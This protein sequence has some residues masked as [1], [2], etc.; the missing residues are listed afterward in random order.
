M[1][2]ACELFATEKFIQELPPDIGDYV[3]EKEPK[4]VSDAADLAAKQF[5]LQ[6]IDEFKYDSSK[7]WTG[8]AKDK[9]SEDKPFRDVRARF[10]GWHGAKCNFK[11][12]AN[13]NTHEQE[14]TKPSD[15]TT[16]SYPQSASKGADSSKSPK[17]F[18]AKT[19]SG[20]GSSKKF[21]GNRHVC[22]KWGHRA[23]DC[24]SRVSVAVVPCLTEPAADALVV[25]G[26]I[27][28]WRVSDM[29]CD[30][31][32]NISMISEHLMPKEPKFCG[33]VV[34]G[35]VGDDTN[36][37]R[38]TLVPT[39]LFGK[40]FKLFVAVAPCLLMLETSLILSS[41]GVWVM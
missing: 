23:A 11:Q 24:R 3:R 28:G 40:A 33:Y 13:S 12:S 39:V 20:S 35:S 41:P 17:A 4:K 5:T 30:S 29:L 31:G 2:D 8:K 36:T 34:V 14:A 18:D 1:H 32:A 19:D 38:A 26:L 37:Y 21:N 25:E 22:G 7:P 9:H 27:D 10:G 15:Q 16:S 6:N